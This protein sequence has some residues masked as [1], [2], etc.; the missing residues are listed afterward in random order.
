MTAFNPTALSFSTFLGNVF[1]FFC[2]VAS[3]TCPQVNVVQV[4]LQ[5][6]RRFVTPTGPSGCKGEL[7]FSWTKEQPPFLSPICSVSISRHL[8][9]REAQLS[10]RYRRVA[11]LHTSWGSAPQSKSVSLLT[12]DEFKCR[13]AVLPQ[14]QATLRINKSCRERKGGVR[15]P[16]LPDAE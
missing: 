16:P 13:G 5:E 3:W 15:L 11:Y 14:P 8:S 7:V 10:S 9:S 4:Y 12:S 6:Y 1:N 2:A